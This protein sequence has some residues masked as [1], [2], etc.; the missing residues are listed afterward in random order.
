VETLLDKCSLYQQAR[1]L[2]Q[3]IIQM[4]PLSQ[5]SNNKTSLPT[6]LID[7]VLNA[8]SHYKPTGSLVQM[9]PASQGNSSSK[10]LVIN[11]W[12]H[13]IKHF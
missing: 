1:L 7:T 12:Q 3:A 8:S 9:G 5:V 2:P 13:F 10:Q 11:S 4:A 6:T